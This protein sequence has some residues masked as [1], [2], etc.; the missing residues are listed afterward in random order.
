MAV[1]RFENWINGL[2]GRRKAYFGAVFLV[3]V[4]VLYAYGAAQQLEHINYKNYWCDQESYIRYAVRLVE[5]D[6][7]YIGDYNR[8]PLYPWLLALQYDQALSEDDFFARAKVFN[9]VLSGV[10]LLGAFVIFTRCFPTLTALNLMLLVTFTVFIFKAPYIQAELLF[11]V[12]N[13]CAF[14]LMMRMLSHPSWRLGMVTGGVLGIAHLTKGSVLVGVGL[15]VFVSGLKIVYTLRTRRFKLAANQIISVLLVVIIYIAVIWPY[16]RTSKRVYGSYFFNLNTTIYMW[17]D[18]WDEV[19]EGA[20]L[21][22]DQEGWPPQPVP[23]MQS[24][25]AEKTPGEILE[26]MARGFVEMMRRHTYRGGYGYIWYILVFLLLV[27]GL[28]VKTYFSPQRARLIRLISQHRFPILFGL[29]YFGVYTGLYIFYVPIHPGLRFMLSLYL[30]FVFMVMI[31][32]QQPIF[33]GRPVRVGTVQM[34]WTTL[35]HLGLFG[36]L[37]LHSLANAIYASG[38]IHGGG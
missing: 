13:F 25:L 29:A 2:T 11:F 20:W 16:I 35:F 8:M 10:A 38:V 15:F 26:R 36:I 1:I 31:L 5:T 24:Y 3:I 12:L 33:A 4:F 14:L 22:R 9:I 18:S 7:R 28:V 32:I 21:Y 30:P 37:V 17:Y 34:Q 6:Y 27:V 23:T 19:R